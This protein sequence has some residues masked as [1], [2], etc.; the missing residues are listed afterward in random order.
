MDENETL[1]YTLDDLD[2]QTH[3]NFEVIVCVNQPEEW[4]NIAEKK[5]VCE[6]NAEMLSQ[7]TRYDKLPLIS[8][9]R[10]TKR[11]G[12]K[13]KRF[14]VGWARKT[15][16]DA[17]HEKAYK[18]DIILTL[19]AD[20]RINPGYLESIAENIE[21]NRNHVGLA[22]PYY[23]RLTGDEIADRAILR[24][25][26]YMRYYSLNMWRIG[27]PYNF[28]AMGSGIAVPS[29][30]YKAVGG[31]TPH[32]SGEDFYFLQKLRKY[33]KLLLWNNEQVYPAS[34]FSTRVFFGTGPAMI[35]GA[36][37]DWDSYPI[38]DHRYFDEIK[39]T[40][41][42]IPEL[43][44]GDVETP[45]SSFLRSQFNIHALWE[46][47]RQ[48]ASTPSQFEKAFHQKIDGLRMLQYLKYRNRQD[49]K[50]NE[51]NLFLFFETYYHD[52][53]KSFSGRIHSFKDALIKDLDELRNAITVK[54]EELQKRHHP[55]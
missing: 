26:I 48:N 11:N 14:G 7:L 43:F 16:M 34:R 15:A 41:E 33:R 12:W 18:N 9:D 37:G 2:H 35:K 3:R 45:M 40:Y 28:T 36:N 20:T 47:I 17:A 6:R 10:C 51:A 49:A 50:S 23:H 31:I 38:Y 1:P 39:S 25:E 8:I 13:G 19:D 32:K 5:A 24:Y 52:I 46:P 30:A 22:V 21:A 54:E 44:K 27:S 55:V 42:L 4:W 29:W 53:Y